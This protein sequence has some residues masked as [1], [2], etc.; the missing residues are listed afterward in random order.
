MLRRRTPVSESVNTTLL[1]SITRKG[2]VAK[3]EFYVVVAF[4]PVTHQPWYV[5]FFIAKEGSVLG[6]MARALAASLSS[7]LREGMTWEKLTKD[8]SS[9]I[10]EPNGPG[11]SG[12]E[13]REFSSLYDALVTT[14]QDAI[15]EYDYAIASLTPPILENPPPP[16]EEPSQALQGLAADG[17]APSASAST[18]ASA[19]SPEPKAIDLLEPA[20]SPAPKAPKVVMPTF[21]EYAPYIRWA[22]DQLPEVVIQALVTQY[23]DFVPEDR[24]YA[25]DLI[26]LACVKD[27]KQALQRLG[28]VHEHLTAHGV[29]A[30]KGEKD[31]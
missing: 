4:H 27:K 22:M 23:L 11:H 18:S 16:L 5:Q 1:S 17:L 31:W 14:A 13:P 10:F 21:K 30:W 15:K 25:I 24:T 19:S 3:H 6:G 7:G 12:G 20:P 9:S 28:E 2:Q 26:L 29:P 8:A